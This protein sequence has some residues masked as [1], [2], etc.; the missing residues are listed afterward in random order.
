MFMNTVE[1]YN[2]VIVR[3][4]TQVLDG[5]EVVLDPLDQLWRGILSDDEG[6]VILQV[7]DAGIAGVDTAGG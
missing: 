6:V 5:D 2:V 1:T 7:T 3:C 4:L